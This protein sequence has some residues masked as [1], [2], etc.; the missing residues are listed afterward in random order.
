MLKLELETDNA[1][2]DDPSEIG[3]ILAVAA[4]EIASGLEVL[5]MDL[6]RP[7]TPVRCGGAMADF[8]GN[9]VGK[10]SLTKEL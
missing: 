7:G 4:R 1:A 2:F 6:N 10:W 9:K 5:R 8:N 3:R